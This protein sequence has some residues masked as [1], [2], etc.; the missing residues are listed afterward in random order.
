[1]NEVHPMKY[2]AF[3]EM[4]NT[5]YLL[6][7]TLNWLYN[8]WDTK[9]QETLSK[10]T[11]VPYDINKINIVIIKPQILLIGLIS[12]PKPGSVRKE[13]VRVAQLLL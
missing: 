10:T 5:F 13:E 7:E 3:T 11:N 9:S 6:L 12:L 1:M 8:S 4:H 2:N